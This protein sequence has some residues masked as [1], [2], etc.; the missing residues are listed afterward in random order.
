MRRFALVTIALFASLPVQ[1]VS[2]KDS[3]YLSL[4]GEPFRTNA[5]GE[6]PFDQWFKLADRDGDG[7]I[8]RLEL[9]Q[10]AQAFFAT[11]DANGDKIID[12]DE[13]ASYERDAPART[14][15]A[16]G[17]VVQL[18][19][20]RPTSTASAPVA[21]GQVAIVTSGTIPSATRVHPGGGHGDVSGVPQPVAMTDLNLDRR[22]TVDEFNK[23]A[24]RRF[25]NYD[26]NQDGKLTSKE[27]R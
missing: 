20:R 18:S 9:Q 16:G 10:D 12:A 14:R 3:V 27:L 17:E 26:T 8:S 5:A 19:S 1:P 21:K 6:P 23:A 25:T 13:M 22:V 7:G 2:A 15:A 4:M 11:L 24:G